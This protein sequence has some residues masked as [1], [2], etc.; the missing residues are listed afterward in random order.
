MSVFMELG[1]GFQKIPGSNQTAALESRNLASM[2]LY[3][4]MIKIFWLK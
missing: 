3:E 4:C 1:N 2:Q